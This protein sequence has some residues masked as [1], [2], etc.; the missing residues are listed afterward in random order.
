[1]HKIGCIA[2]EKLVNLD[3]GGDRDES[4]H[5][6]VGHRASYLELREKEVLTVSGKIQV[7]RNYY[8]DRFCGKGW[9]PKDGELSIVSSSFSP[10][11]RRIMGRV[12]S[13]RPFAVGA[14]EIRC[15]LLSRRWEGFW[16]H[17]AEVA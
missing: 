6:A 10:R 5:C 15:C 9:C 8:Y 17:M 13:S 14:E 7:Q 4:Q 12:G 11:V 1:M 2:L 16:T 3:G